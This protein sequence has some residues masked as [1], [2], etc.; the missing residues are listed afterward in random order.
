[1]R[2][3]FYYSTILLLSAILV[4]CSSGRIDSIE[5]GPNE[6]IVIARY[7]LDDVGD[8]VTQESSL[9]FDSKLLDDIS[10]SPDEANY[11]YFKMPIGE[12]YLASIYTKGKSQNIGENF[13]T[14]TIPDGNIY[15]IG[16]ISITGALHK[17]H[18]LPGGIIGLLADQNHICVDPLIKIEND[19]EK[20][21]KY[22]RS[23]FNTDEKIH[24]LK[25]VIVPSNQ[26]IDTTD[27]NHK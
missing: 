23:L 1:M 3:T 18:H 21:V 13:F 17:H 8:D 4:S 27:R 25:V 11:I 15:Y 9:R 6:A 12:F 20:D 19:Y 14:I 16:N 5:R 7:T 10:V 26:Y 22:F 24:E 2:K